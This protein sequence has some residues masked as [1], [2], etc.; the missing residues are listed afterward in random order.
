MFRSQGHYSLASAQLLCTRTPGLSTLNFN[1]Y[2][3]TSAG[4]TGT[5]IAAITV[6]ASGWVTSQAWQSF[7]FG[8]S[9]VLD[10]GSLYGCIC[11]TTSTSSA[12][13]LAWR[14]ETVNITEHKNIRSTNY[15]S[16]WII[17]SDSCLL[18]TVFGS[19]V[20][21]YPTGNISGVSYLSAFPPRL[22]EYMTGAVS[23]ASFVSAAAPVI[24]RYCSGTLL[25][26]SFISADSPRA[27]M[28]I[29]GAISGISYVSAY[30]PGVQ[31][32]FSG[33]ITGQGVISS[34]VFVVTRYLTGDTIY[35]VGYLS[36]VEA[37]GVIH[38]L[39]GT[40]SGIAYI[41]VWLNKQANQINIV[42]NISAAPHHTRDG[43]D[44]LLVKGGVESQGGYFTDD[45]VGQTIT[46]T[47]QDG[48]TVTVSRGIIIAIS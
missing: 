19:G 20:T 15:G 2:N 31:R 35:G 41:S 39:T 13:P 26:T 42:S 18:F 22:D 28:Y 4:P 48:R 12:T 8:N 40:I 7:N 47:A 34:L 17:L 32:Y 27:D 43:S 6:D 14:N 23:A 3:C 37:A 38:Y 25:G 36:E 9:A 46:F 45:G 24:T 10:S 33:N 30:S 11:E 1:I 21:Y 29:T 5:A 44:G 16:S